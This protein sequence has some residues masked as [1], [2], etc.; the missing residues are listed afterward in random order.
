LQNS[1]THPDLQLTGLVS[2]LASENAS[3]ITISSLRG[4]GSGQC[5]G[6]GKETESSATLNTLQ[7]K[8]DKLIRRIAL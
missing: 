5:S 8:Y 6:S 4:L 3:S 2:D 1:K 7:I